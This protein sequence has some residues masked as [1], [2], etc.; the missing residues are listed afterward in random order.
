MDALT[1][2]PYGGI[3][4]LVVLLVVFELTNA[5]QRN[6]KPRNEYEFITAA[7]NCV[8]IRHVLG[9]IYN[10]YTSE[11]CPVVTKTDRYGRYF[12]VTARSASEAEYKIDKLYGS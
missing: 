7:G 11:D 12:T 9:A 8:R 3:L 6:G 1:I 5:Q 4:V 2:L 10:V